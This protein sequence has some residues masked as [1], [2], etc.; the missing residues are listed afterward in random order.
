MPS[1]GP[2]R[3]RSP[4]NRVAALIAGFVLSLGLLPATVAAADPA[5][6]LTFRSVAK[7]TISGAKKVGR[8]L[9]AKPKS[10]PAATQWGYQWHRDDQPIDGATAKQYRLT[11]ADYGK[12]IT[13]TATARLD[14]YRPTTS[15][16]AR[17]GKIKRGKL[18]VKA[19]AITGRAEIGGQLIATTPGWTEGTAFS[20]QWYRNGKKISKANRPYYVPTSADK[21]KRLSV[22]VTGRQ[23]GY[24]SASRTSK[25]T[26]TVKLAAVPEAHR[27]RV[28]SFNVTVASATADSTDPLKRPW[29]ERMPE[30]VKQI[31]DERLHLVG[32]QE[33]SAGTSSTDS[34][35]PQFQELA[36]ALGQ[37]W[38]LT[39][40]VR[41]CD[42]AGAYQR[43][44]NGAGQNDRILYR[45]DRLELLR[46]GSRKL[47]AK[48]S[49]AN[50]GARFVVWAEFRDLVTGKRFLFFNTHLEPLKSGGK[51]VHGK[52]ASV[53]LDEIEAQN[54]DGLPV[55]LV[56]DLAS[57][58]FAKPNTARDAFVKAGFVDSLGNNHRQKTAKGI[59]AEKVVNGDVNSINYFKE[60]PQRV[61]GY[62]LGSYLDYILVSTARIRV[63]EWKTVVGRLDK[64]RFADVIPSDHHLVRAIVALP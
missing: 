51:Q 11:G 14:G 59:H 32:V 43:C 64:G 48:T 15:R 58:K 57:T 54:P 46:Q 49:Y 19:P 6:P 38:A 61:G 60:R 33:A 28:G 45:T 52:Q 8:V 18:A 10:R 25:K 23:P 26:G 53:I 56:G 4:L 7:P 37:P 50:G 47:D 16:S 36:D 21:G 35:R 20:H 63:L 3:K 41:Y 29:G 55:I 1:R 24:A 5:D 31:K 30:A 9:T 27:L 22:K 13:V 2:N 42:T 62:R 44:P 34:G 17:T 12:R 40:E 39:N